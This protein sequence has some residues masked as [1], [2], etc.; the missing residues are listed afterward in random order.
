LKIAPAAILSLTFAGTAFGFVA[1]NAAQLENGEAVVTV[2][3]ASPQPQAA[4]P[5]DN[6]EA[7]FADAP[8]GVD[9]IVTGPVSAAFKRTQNVLRCADA[10]WPNVPLACYPD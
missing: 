5:D 1:A 9:P 10:V 7:L 6:T 8:D 3:L 2:A 4:L